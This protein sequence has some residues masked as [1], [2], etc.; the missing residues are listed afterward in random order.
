MTRRYKRAGCL[1]RILLIIG[2][3]LFFFRYGWA[4]WEWC[5]LG[6]GIILYITGLKRGGNLELLFPGT[7]LLAF[8][9]AFLLRR[10]DL[11]AFQLWR[12]WPILFCS[13][14][15]G[16]TL[17]WTVR[18]NGAWVFIPGGFLLLISGG[19]FSARSFFRYQVWLRGI[20]DLWPLLLFLTIV[21]LFVYYWRSQSVKRGT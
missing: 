16:F 13:M 12:M 3:G 17:M 20:V 11:V 15:L 4:A 19:G 14:G 2:L 1:G 9:G 6:L 5:F 18:H 7:I 10:F 8:G 21:F